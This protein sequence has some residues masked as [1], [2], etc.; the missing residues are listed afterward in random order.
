M[1][2][3]A[4][5]QML[6]VVELP[7]QQTWEKLI[8]LKVS[9]SKLALEIKWPNKARDTSFAFREFIISSKSL[10]RIALEIPWNF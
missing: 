9:A 8:L 7:K 5:L 1:T 2:C 10:S 6:W 3:L 4:Y